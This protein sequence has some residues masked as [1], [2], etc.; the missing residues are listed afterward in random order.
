M[1]AK[2]DELLYFGIRARGEATRMLYA[3]AG[4]GLT[5]KRITFDEWA[6]MKPCKCSELSYLSS[7]AGISSN[8][9]TGSI[10][11]HNFSPFSVLAWSYFEKGEKKTKKL[12]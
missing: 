11:Q 7:P 6:E 9:N 5:D 3:I 2:K 8:I 10:H 4:K 12:M 1:A